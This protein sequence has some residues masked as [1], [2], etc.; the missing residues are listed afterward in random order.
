[1]KVTRERLGYVFFFAFF[2][3]QLKGIV[4]F[5]LSGLLLDDH[6]G[7]ELDQ[8]H[9][10]GPTGLLDKGRLA[11]FAADHGDDLTHGLIPSVTA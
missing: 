4:T 2:K 7:T 11:Q 5:L 8:G 9:V 10:R 6:T 3:T 1:L